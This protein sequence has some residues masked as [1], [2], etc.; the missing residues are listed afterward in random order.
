MSASLNSKAHSLAAS[1]RI[2][3]QKMEDPSGGCWERLGEAFGLFGQR[4]GAARVTHSLL[5][6]I[7]ILHDYYK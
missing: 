6:A 2:F 1:A 7:L 3:F 5:L 4:I